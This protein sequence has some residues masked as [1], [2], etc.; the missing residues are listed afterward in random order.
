MCTVNVSAVESDGNIR[1][2]IADNGCGIPP[3]HLPNVKKKF[4]KAN[5]TIR[6]SGI[7]LALANEIMTLHAGSLEI[8]SQEN[9]G[10]AVTII[11]PTLEELE[12]QKQEESVPE[13]SVASPA[14]K[15]GTEERNTENHG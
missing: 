15:D 5:Q 10:T 8:E 7:G 6:G 3:D 1:V 4:Y 9:V 11:I 12:A 13:T 14:E 2:I